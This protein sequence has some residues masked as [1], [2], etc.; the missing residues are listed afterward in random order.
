MGEVDTLELNADI[1]EIQ[2]QVL[3]HTELTP[4]DKEL[5][6]TTELVYDINGKQI[7]DAKEF[8]SD[9]YIIKDAQDS[10]TG[11]AKQSITPQRN[12]ARLIGCVVL[13]ILIGLH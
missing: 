4:V 3:K 9:N 12:T 5:L 10:Q 6:I 13:G 7:K 8:P 11:V 2:T 1:N